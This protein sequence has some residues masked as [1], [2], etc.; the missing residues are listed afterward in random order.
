MCAGDAVY[1]EVVSCEKW[2]CLV[3][4]RRKR[5]VKSRFHYRKAVV[6]LKRDAQPVNGGRIFRF[7]LPKG[8][9]PIEAKPPRKRSALP[10]SFPLPKGGGPI[11]ASSAASGNSASPKFPLPKGG[12]PI[13]A[14]PS[15]GACSRSWAFPPPKGGGPIEATRSVLPRW[16]F[17]KVSTTERRWPH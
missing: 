10:P 5:A 12:G 13:E 8:G 2:L 9:G 14:C 1:P 6:P 16:H 15:R 17:G 3:H 7:P 4:P 11:E